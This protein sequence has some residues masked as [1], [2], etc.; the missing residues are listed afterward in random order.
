MPMFPSYRNQPIDLH[1]KSIDWFL[2]AGTIGM[3]RVCKELLV[4]IYQE[5]C[6]FDWTL[7][8]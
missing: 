8:F 3:K 2:Y 5:N 7:M 4:E 6:D 1:S